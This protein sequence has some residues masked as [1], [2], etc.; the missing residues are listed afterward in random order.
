MR[1]PYP[2]SGKSND[3][4]KMTARESFLYAMGW[5]WFVV[6]FIG[7]FLPL[8]PTVP[9]W[10][11]SAACW[12]RSSP[13]MHGWLLARPKVGPVIAEWE[14]HGTI[15]PRAKAFSVGTMAVL[16]SY[17]IFF[18]HMQLWAKAGVAITFVCVSLFI[19]TR[20]SEAGAVR[21]SK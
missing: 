8:L 5:F 2:M 20:P 13:Q 18:R 14:K 16:M 1:R 9:F 10:L 15:R 3:Q 17:P 4:K 11:I 6:G 19:L 7:A 12:A 21:K